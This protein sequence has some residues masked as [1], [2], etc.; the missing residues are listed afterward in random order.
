MPLLD[1]FRDRMRSLAPRAGPAIVAVSGGPDSAALLDLLVR[2]TPTHGLELIVAHA[3]HGIDPGS[4]RIADAVSALATAHGLPV[5]IG[6]LQL[7]TGASETV[8]R[9]RRYAWLESVRLARGANVILT[10]H[11]ADDQTETIVMRFLRGSGPAGL[12]GM[13]D[14]AGPILRPLLPFR[15]ESLARYVHE[16]GLSDWSDP[17]NADPRHLRSWIRGELLPQVV[18]RLPDLSER[19]GSVA[20]QARLGREAWDRVLEALPT[21]DSRRD[22]DGFSVAAA[23]LAGYDSALG[24][25]IVAALGRRAGRIIGPRRAHAILALARNGESGRYVP[26]G[27]GWVAEIAFRRLRLRPPE[28]EPGAP[29]EL[30]GPSGEIAWGG[31]RV[32]WMPGAAPAGQARRSME[33]WLSA[34][35]A[36]ELRSPMPG[37]RIFPLGGTGRRLLVRC[38]QDARVPR[39]RRRDWPVLAVG[40]EIAWVPGVCRSAT[41]LPVE[42]AEA[43]RVDVAYA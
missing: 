41:H 30:T 40:G 3:D 36:V 17:A 7:G 33:T 9:E 22:D 8:A 11:H 10:G 12:S 27:G 1:E 42:G 4:P 16:R 39:S 43:V 19:V 37:E 34:G 2:S 35:A 13:A 20:E 26:L 6:R 24:I 38:F 5:E 15:R 18:A 32:R 29:V 14:R 25:A 31:W 28:L 23:P 21:L